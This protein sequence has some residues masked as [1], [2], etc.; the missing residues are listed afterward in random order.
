[1]RAVILA[2]GIGSRLGD[3]TTTRPKT[4]L[5]LNG[6]SFFQRLL[7]SLQAAEIK[8]VFYVSGHAPNVLRVEAEPF[9]GL[10][11][12]R[13]V[14]NE[15]FREYNN[16]YSLWI[17]REHL[18]GRPFILLNSDIIFESEFLIDIAQLQEGN[19]L[20]VDTESPVNEEAMKVVEE[21]DQLVAIGK[22]L[23]LSR[24]TGEY[25][26]IA[27]FDELGSRL[28]FE[29]VEKVISAGG[30]DNWYEYA[31]GKIFDKVPFRIANVKGGT[32]MEVDD[33]NDLARASELAVALDT[34]RR[35]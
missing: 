23:S 26:G 19:W 5:S 33:L 11:N 1:M 20:A 4:S 35:G 34:N 18:D 21:G 14:W 17:M 27:R 28:L 13:E 24:S 30:V 2:A 6:R 8:D 9:N 7:A 12:V 25:I 10:M 16:I 3:L 29:E 31:I 22:R 15:K 32:W